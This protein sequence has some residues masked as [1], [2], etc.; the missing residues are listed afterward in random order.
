MLLLVGQINQAST[1][2]AALPCMYDTTDGRLLFTIPCRDAQNVEF[3]PLGT[4]L[5]TWSRP[6]KGTAS[7]ASEGNLRVWKLPTIAM[8]REGGGAQAECELVAAY[9]QKMNKRDI[10][11]WTHD[12][13]L[14]LR[15]V[16][17]EIHIMKGD[18]LKAGIIAKVHHKGVASYK[19][20]ELQGEERRGMKE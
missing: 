10:L 5:V 4:Y 19:V 6:T 15:V 9:S 3:S 7:E 18:D 20:S 16:S 2:D 12:E 11:Q 14:C 17:N 1:G 8:A 13:A